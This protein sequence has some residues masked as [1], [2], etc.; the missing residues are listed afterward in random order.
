VAQLSVRFERGEADHLFEV[1]FGGQALTKNFL[2]KPDL[3]ALMHYHKEDNP[4]LIVCVFSRGCNSNI[5]Q[6]YKLRNF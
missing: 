6:K 2:D 3:H 1:A 4:L 5:S